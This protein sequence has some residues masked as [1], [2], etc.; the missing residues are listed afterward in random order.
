MIAAYFILLNTIGFA[1]PVIPK[2]PWNYIN[3][4]WVKVEFL[5]QDS[6][7]DRT[8]GHWNKQGKWVS[9]YWEHR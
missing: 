4:T 2:G 8:P 3:G 5:D 9:G 1:A 6:P 7:W